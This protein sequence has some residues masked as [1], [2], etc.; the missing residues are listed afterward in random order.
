MGTGGAQGP[1]LLLKSQQ[2]VRLSNADQLLCSLLYNG[3]N[4]ISLP[5]DGSG[6]D[7]SGAAVS[8]DSETLAQAITAA[9]ANVRSIVKWD[10]LRGRWDIHQTGSDLGIWELELGRA[11]FVKTTNSASFPFTGRPVTTPIPLAFGVGWHLISVPF[12]PTA[13]DSETLT[14][15][16]DGSGV[17]VVSVVRWDSLRG[18]WDIHQKGNELGIWPI[19]KGK[20]YFVRTLNPGSWTP[21]Q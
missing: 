16:I 14:Q 7:S 3:W 1:A 12:S 11:Y 2:A 17:S 13:Y 4:L 19:E 10:N 21:G 6:S 9:G 8:Y 20:G 15:A 18:R 5:N